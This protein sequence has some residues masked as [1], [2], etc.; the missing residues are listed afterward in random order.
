MRGIMLRSLDSR[1]DGAGRDNK[2]SFPSPTLPP[3]D[4]NYNYFH[5]DRQ[6]L[7]YREGLKSVTRVRRGLPWGP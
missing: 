2:F 6:G 7:T 5:D 3:A 4:G 1:G